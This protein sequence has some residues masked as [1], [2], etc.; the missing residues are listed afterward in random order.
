MLLVWPEKVLTQ[1]PDCT[2]HNFMFVP[3]DKTCDPSGLN[4]M[5][6]TKKPSSTLMVFTIVP[7]CTDH[8]F[9]V[10][11][12]EQENT[13]LPSRLNATPTMAR[14]SCPPNVRRHFPDATH[15]E[16]FGYL[17]RKGEILLS[18]KGGKWKGCFHVPRGLW[19]CWQALE[20]M[21]T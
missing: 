21:R 16:W 8:M 4:A 15:G 18:L 5:A 11:S 6:Y 7:N 17:N 13:V 14:L 1:L 20:R 12:I 2:D 19:Q 9:K 3:P 10:P